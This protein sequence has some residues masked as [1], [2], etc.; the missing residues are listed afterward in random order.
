MRRDAPSHTRPTAT[1]TDVAENAAR[2][3]ADLKLLALPV[4]DIENK[5]VGVVKHDEVMEAGILE[6]FEDSSHPPNWD[7]VPEVSFFMGHPMK[8]S[9]FEA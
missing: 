7:C 6:A 4:V 1:V 5:L 3:C 9:I 2:R 8:I